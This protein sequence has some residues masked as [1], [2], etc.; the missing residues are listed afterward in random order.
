M[1]FVSHVIS[2]A[3]DI[4]RKLKEVFVGVVGVAEE[5]YGVSTD[6]VDDE[7]SVSEY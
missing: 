6:G 1:C 4:V 2:R 7:G 5:V 3:D